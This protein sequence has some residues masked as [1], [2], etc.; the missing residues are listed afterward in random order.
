MHHQHVR[1]RTKIHS[2]IGKDTLADPGFAGMMRP[3]PIDMPELK[4]RKQEKG[5]VT[6]SRKADGVSRN[7]HGRI[8]LG[9]GPCALAKSFASMETRRH[10]VGRA[11]SAQSRPC[12]SG[13]VQSNPDR[14]LLGREILGWQRKGPLHRC[15]TGQQQKPTRSPVCSRFHV[16]GQAAQGGLDEACVSRC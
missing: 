6:G 11:A 3:V 16:V 1:Q 4:Q 2:D 14:T 12:W 8:L 10:D 7:C 15:Q 13:L 9:Q 5:N